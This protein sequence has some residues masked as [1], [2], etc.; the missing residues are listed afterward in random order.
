[1]TA[2]TIRSLMTPIE[3]SNIKGACYSDN[4]L[5]LTFKEGLIYQY[6][7]V[8]DS[9]YMAFMAS[10]SK[11]KFFSDFIRNTYTGVV[12]QEGK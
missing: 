8:P 9:V 6:Q 7:E 2:E 12:V 3:S 5:Y 4:T 1:M 11:G 10:E